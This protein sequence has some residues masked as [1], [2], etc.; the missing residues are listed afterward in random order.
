MEDLLVGGN[1]ADAGGGWLPG[2]GV[3]VR[4]REGGAGHLHPDAVAA[5][6]AVAGRPQVHIHAPYTLGVGGDLPGTAEP[7]AMTVT[8][9]G[10]PDW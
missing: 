9:R 10:V 8:G 2:A 7:G 3:A 6:E 1:Q 4:A 5:V